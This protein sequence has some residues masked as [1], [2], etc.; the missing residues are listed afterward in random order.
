MSNR[1]I[2]VGTNNRLGIGTVAPSKTLDFTG[3]YFRYVITQAIKLEHLS[4]SVFI[5]M[6]DDNA[7]DVDIGEILAYCRVSDVGILTYNPGDV[8]G[9]INSDIF[10]KIKEQYESETR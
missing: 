3:D 9:Q 2:W 10:Y 6:V 4:G 1:T 5:Y 7:P 8:R